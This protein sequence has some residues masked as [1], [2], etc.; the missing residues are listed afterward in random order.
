MK[1]HRILPIVF[2][3]IGII[4]LGFGSFSMITKDDDTEKKKENKEEDNQN[5]ELMTEEDKKEVEKFLNEKY[6][7]KYQNF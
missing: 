4:S 6:D 5:N 7:D 1:I 2:L 3:V